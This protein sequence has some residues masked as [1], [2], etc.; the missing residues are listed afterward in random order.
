[1]GTESGIS[2]RDFLTRSASGVAAVGLAGLAPAAD[3]SGETPKPAPA[4]KREP[5]YRPLGRTGIRLPVVNMGVMNADLPALVRRSYELGVRH[6]DTAA[7]YQ[8]GRN[9][10]MVGRVIKELGVRDKVVIATKVYI[11]DPERGRP[12]AEAREFFLKSAEESLRRLQ[13]DYLDILYSHRVETLDFQNNPGIRE[14]L[15]QLKEQKKVRFIGFSTHTNMAE[16]INDAARSGFWDVIL[17][18]FN[19]SFHD[20][21]PLREAMRAASGKG[22]GLIAMKT[23]CQQPWY[24]EGSPESTRKFYEGKLMHTALLKWVLRHEFITCAIPGYTTFQQLEEDFPVASDLTLN[25]AEE[26]FLKDRQVLLAMQSVCRQCARCVPTCP[27][28]A[29][30][31]NLMRAHMYAASYVNFRQARDTRRD[32]AAGRGLDACA[33]CPSCSARCARRV[34]IPRRVEELKTIYL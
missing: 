9:E 6:F 23:Q 22:I 8:R 21:Q 15:Q 13:T 12:P 24:K 14:A 7:Y 17:T 33:A 2:R 31:P 27:H 19:Y 30:I 26:Q 5:I 16:C 4:A 25:P 34:D 28:G 3:P 29:D 32:I 1:M 18:A 20:Y 11:N 10:E